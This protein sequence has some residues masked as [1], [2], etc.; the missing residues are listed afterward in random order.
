MKP[1]D[2]YKYTCENYNMT[3]K[4]KAFKDIDCIREKDEVIFLSAITSLF[5]SGYANYTK[6]TKLKLIE[7][8]RGEFGDSDAE[9]VKSI[10]ISWLSEK[11]FITS[12]AKQ[13]RID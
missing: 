3:P 5:E 12:S 6:E 4:P 7:L 9:I 10:V 13:K 1:I 8:L 11:S 2:M